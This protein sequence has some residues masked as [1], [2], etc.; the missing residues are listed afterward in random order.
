[1]G[2]TL[3]DGNELTLSN[4]GTGELRIV[5]GEQHVNG[6]ILPALYVGSFF[7]LHHFWL[8][9]VIVVLGIIILLHDLRYHVITDTLDKMW[10]NLR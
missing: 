2:I 1:M 3:L 4:D 9:V 7:K 5:L 6:D 10:N 8:G